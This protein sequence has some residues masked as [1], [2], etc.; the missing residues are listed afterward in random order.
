MNNFIFEDKIQLIK[1]KHTQEYL[2]E[3]L[4]TY[5]NKEYR[6]C[7]ILLYATVFTDLL[8]KFKL[9]AE[10]YNDKRCEKFLEKY[11]KERK[12]N[13]KYSK[14]EE[15][16]IEFAVKTGFLNDVE[17]K[18]LRHLKDHRDYCAHPVVCENLQLISPTQEQVRAQIRNMF[19][20][21]FL[22]DAIINN[23]I[24]SEFLSS[25]ESFYDRNGTENLE[26]YLNSRYLT[27][28]NIKTKKKLLKE[29]WKFIF[30]YPED[31]DCK[32]YRQVV[33]ASFIALFQ[34]N[35]SELYQFMSE[36]KA[37]FNGKI[38]FEKIDVDLNDKKPKWY[39]YTSTCLIL[40]LYRIPKIYNIISTANIV[41]IKSIVSRNINF[42][43]S[44]RYLY[45][46]TE[47]HI[48]NLKKLITSNDLNFCINPQLMLKINSSALQDFDISYQNFII[49]YFQN[50]QNS[51][52]FSPDYDFIN[53]T[54]TEL[55]SQIIDSLTK[56]Q[57]KILL[58]GL[59]YSNIRS[60][61][62]II[63]AQKI[64]DTC[65]SKKIDI[66]FKEYQINIEE[67]IQG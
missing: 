8:E 20:S 62:F 10:Y 36:E 49:Y 56:E 17:K 50:C 25:I 40:M 55:L 24:C 35:E 30:C 9:L 15:E 3:V 63:M 39:K 54:Y 28:L 4:S 41:E 7:I 27:H 65:K 53:N 21:I 18:Q 26:K 46:S 48:K 22:K 11:K 23:D 38:T 2:D 66:N 5:H 33:Y 43:L 60:N 14:L 44:A 42:M 52:C 19:D 45:S 37:F 47:D 31:N 51:Y 58:E 57:I 67:Y 6:S 16:V 59:S 29:L 12:E 61:T 13:T 34:T 1:N 32:K 64:Y